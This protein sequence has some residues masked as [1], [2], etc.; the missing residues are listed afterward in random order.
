LPRNEESK[1]IHETSLDVL[2]ACG[3][4]E[5]DGKGRG[6]VG[7]L[8][9]IKHRSIKPIMPAYCN[10]RVPRIFPIRRGGELF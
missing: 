4:D 2:Y 6:R 7:W 3:K 9:K 10:G 5:K 8:R 1:Q